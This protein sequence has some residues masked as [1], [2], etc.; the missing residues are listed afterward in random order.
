VKPHPQGQELED[1]IREFGRNNSHLAAKTK[2]N[3][4]AWFVSN[5]HTPG[6]REKLVHKMRKRVQ[7]IEIIDNLENLLHISA[8][9]QDMGHVTTMV[10]PGHCLYKDT[11]AAHVN[12][13]L[14]Y[15]F[16]YL[17]YSSS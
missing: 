11:L 16:L 9:V 13:H 2:T 7:V 1:F 17:Q 14:M 15:H 12:V 6:G 3:F 4:A 8:D 5:C 10:A